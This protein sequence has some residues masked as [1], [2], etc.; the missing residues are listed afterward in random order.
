[1]EMPTQRVRNNDGA[2]LHEIVHIYAPND[3]RFLA[4]GLAVY[5][6][7]KMGGN[8]A[9]P[10]FGRN[11]N[12]SARQRLSEVNSLTRLNSVQTPRPLST[13]ANERT[14]YILA[15][16]FVAF[17]IEK[18]GLPHF[19]TLYETGDYGTVYGKSLQVLEKEWRS[20]LE[21]K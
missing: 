9:F 12:V 21:G 7:D 15:G 6:Q 13:V 11:L 1:M 10:N 19:K 3:N 2:L 18:Y 20:A 14:A 8:G 5:L 16:S 17:L 4:E